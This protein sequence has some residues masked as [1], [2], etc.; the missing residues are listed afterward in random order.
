MPNQEILWDKPMTV[1]SISFVIDLVRTYHYQKKD[2]PQAIKNLDYSA[3][4]I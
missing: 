1:T 2:P 3:I 4:G